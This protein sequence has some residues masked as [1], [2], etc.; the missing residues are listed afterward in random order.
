LGGGFDY[1]DLAEA[2]VATSRLASIAQVA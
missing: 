1:L 2:I